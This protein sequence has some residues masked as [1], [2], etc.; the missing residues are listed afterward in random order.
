[1]RWLR[2]L[3]RGLVIGSAALL[4]LCGAFALA[5]QQLP[6]LPAVGVARDAVLRAAAQLPGPSDRLPELLERVSAPPLCYAILPAGLVLLFGMLLPG[7][8]RAQTPGPASNDALR[9]VDP[10]TQSRAEKE[11]RSLSRRGQHDAAAELLFDVGCMEEAAAEFIRAGEFERAA[12]IRHDQNRFL[13]SA[14]LYLKAGKPEPA[15]SIYAQQKEF[16]KAADAY[17]EAG[18]KSVAAELFEQAGRHL[19]AARNYSETNFHRHAAQAYL[20]CD[21]GEEAARE[22]LRVISDE[23]AGARSETQI[24]EMRKLHKMAGSLFE[25]AGKLEEA[26]QVLVRG[27]AQQA[28]A[29][30]ALRR[31]NLD[32]AASWF[33]EAGQA[34]RAA[35]ILRQTGDTQRA[36]LVLAEHYRDRGQEELAAQH[37]A[38][39]GDALA[40][41]ELYRSIG[42]A[43]EA[44]RCFEQAG[45]ASQAA[46]LYRAA[47]ETGRAA[48]CFERSG[49]FESAAECC[50][51]LGESA[52]EAELLGKAGLFLRAAELHQRE[53]RSDE[54]I[55]MLQ[56]IAPEAADFAAAS[57]LLGSV[58]SQGG[59]HA[60]AI[61]Q[62][63]AAL[64]GQ[65]LTRSNAKVYYQL[66]CCCEA[67]G[68]WRRACEIYE[69]IQTLDYHYGDVAQRIE[70][71][72]AA[73]AREESAKPA[74]P[75]RAAGAGAASA[76]SAS[77][78]IGRYEVIGE[79]GRG[80]MGIVYK[81]R[82]T[83]LDRIV[84]LKVLPDTLKENPQALKNFLREA[85]AAAQLNHP[86][87]VTVYDAGEQLGVWY[88]AMEF[89]DGLTLKQI[90]RQRGR[91]AA[92]GVVHVLVQLCEALA[93][94]H[95][96]KIVHRDIKTANTMWTGDRK[97]K[98][99][100]F[101]L[102]RV[103]EE[104]RNHTTVV[105]GTPYYMSPEQTLGQAI[106]PRTDLYSLG[107]T[108]FELATG[109]LPFTEGNLP[110]H[111]VHTPPPDPRAV[112]PDLPDALARLILRCL[113]KD[114]A[115][116][117]QSAR[118]LLAELR[119]SALARGRAGSAG[120]GT[121]AAG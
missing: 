22:L 57:A 71:A 105:S 119:A 95:E 26:E 102:A 77:R 96:K 3:G 65:A 15:G 19:D 75:A 54:A 29:E 101:G 23:A 99:M 73:L 11:A 115:H 28:A 116:R 113:Q 4:A 47:G 79:L 64:A 38:E 60:L 89:V 55:R 93:Y 7:R 68:E 27:G 45:D 40:A 32:Q 33:L 110:Y 87:I 52:R 8:S 107:V 6:E 94:A 25:R 24:A 39:G 49:R 31:G 58:F 69:G 80:G 76:Q 66:A 13:E 109:K 112:V 78:A 36:A 46:D 2:H 86:G 82:D 90:V 98:I 59:K 37:F 51:L 91:I 72:R 41:G 20:R 10:K 48:E 88:I 97:V 104:V 30:I 44:A 16:A 117:Y 83:V 61:K 106:D 9:H 81:A 14:E 18:N 70:R 121:R 17:L 118:E 53:G 50:A 120:G 42:A 108:I 43:A 100:D 84:A 114:P 67:A 62:L 21:R 1:M 63:E 74:A 34:E 5:L 35:L 92:G 85:K 111:H 103:V 12:E 56:K